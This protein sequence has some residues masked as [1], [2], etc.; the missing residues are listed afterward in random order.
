MTEFEAKRSAA[1]RLL[2][3]TPIKAANFL[4][5]MVL[6]MWRLG[7]QVP[8]PH[9]ASFGLNALWSGTFFGVIWGTFMWLFQWR[10]EPFFVV[11][12]APV[13]AGIL[14]G[15]I[16]ALYYAH[17]HKKYKLPNWKDLP[18]ASNS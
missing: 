6:L 12:G 13:L 1:V 18:G 15:L 9:F 14:F 4:P 16:W 5:P 7:I 10:Q 17:A 11:I 8:P 3:Q 2:Q